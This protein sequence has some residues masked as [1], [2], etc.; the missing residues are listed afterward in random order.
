MNRE[1]PKMTGPMIGA[2]SLLVIFAILCMTVFSLLGLSTVS[3]HK[4]LSD[5]QSQAFTD[6]YAADC[7]AEE[8]LAQL[9]SG[10]IPHGVIVDDVI[11]RYTCPISPTQEL[12]VEVHRNDWSILRWQAVSTV[13]WQA[14]ESITVWDG[15]ADLED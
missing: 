12:Q 6:Y 1:N 10:Q 9:R 13:R 11:C 4:R 5:I 15:S 2:S 7:R 3:A 14:D 8:I